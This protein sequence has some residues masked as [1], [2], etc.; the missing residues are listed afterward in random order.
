MLLLDF[1]LDWGVGFEGRVIFHQ[2]EQS[3]GFLVVPNLRH[4]DHLH[5][6]QW[7]CIVAMPGPAADIERC[8]AFFKLR[9][10]SSE[11]L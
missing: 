9:H 6:Q 5:L 8:R 11:G 2:K 1:L 3:R 4:P 10:A 7:M